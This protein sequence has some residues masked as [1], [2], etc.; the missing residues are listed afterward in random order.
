MQQ[1]FKDT[2]YL[3]YRN[4]V[5]GGNVTV[6]RTKND[7]EPSE[8]DFKQDNI[9]ML[10]HTSTLNQIAV[11]KK[12][13]KIVRKILNTEKVLL[14]QSV[15]CA[16]YGRPACTYT[17]AHNRDQ[18]M[19]MSNE[20]EPPVA[21]AAIVYYSDTSETET[22]GA[23]VIVPRTG[24]DDTVDTCPDTHMSG[25]SGKPFANRR[26][27]AEEIMSV[28]DEEC[29]E[30]VPEFK[31]GDVLFY[32]T[33]TCHRDTPV[34]EGETHYAHH[35]AWR[36]ADA[37]DLQPPGFEQKMYFGDDT[38]ELEPD[39]L[40]TLGFTPRDDPRWKNEMFMAAMNQRYQWAGFDAKRYMKYENPP[41]VPRFWH[42][43][44]L[45]LR[46]TASANDVREKLFQILHDLDVN[47]EAVSS[48]WKYRLQKVC[49]DAYIDIQCHFF[50]QDSAEIAV[51][52]NLLS[53]DRFVWH[54]MAQNIRVMFA[55]GN[56]KGEC[57][58]PR[59]YPFRTDQLFQ[60][61]EHG[62]MNDKRRAMRSLAL[63]T[64]NTDI[65]KIVPWIN[66]PMGTFLEKEIQR[67]AEYIKVNRAHL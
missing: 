35:L 24:R 18:R 41:P 2:G 21:V 47:V 49:G 31:P 10:P 4:L 57:Y 19:Y 8:K 48:F 55:G 1:H 58:K 46:S 67:W 22:G 54:H 16:K 45:T 53:G 50:K 60:L 23:T 32:R 14:I 17:S 37:V 38:F 39:Q 56:A 52:I 33:D 61:L 59:D 43:A 3:I 29:V 66:K 51:D 11:D 27:E 64:T 26:E 15:P 13:L 7:S 12:I 30:I 9:A 63:S 5:S 42:F 25:I 6:G 36:C 28:F 62:S 65:S 34:K 44:P 20:N 40:E